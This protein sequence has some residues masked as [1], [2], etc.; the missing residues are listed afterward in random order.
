MFDR[1]A[2]GVHP[3]PKCPALPGWKTYPLPR[4]SG[5]L[6]GGDDSSVRAGEGGGVVAIQS[7]V[8]SLG[9]PRLR[10]D[11]IGGWNLQVDGEAVAVAP[12]VQRLL[13][14]VALRDR[15][16]RPV[17]AAT[18]WPDC[19]DPRAQANLRSAI[20]RANRI[21]VDLLV[22]RVGRLSLGPG[23]DV[24]VHALTAGYRA[25]EPSAATDRLDAS[26]DGELLPGW[27]DHWVL[28]ERELVRQKWL[29]FLEELGTRL[30]AEGRYEQALEATLAAVRAE[31][32]RESAHRLLIN[33]HLAEGN[34]GEARRSY[35]R[36]RNLLEQ[37][38]GLEP[39]PLCAAIDSRLKG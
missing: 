39:S 2:Q 4:A 8:G 32:L 9:Q 20:W 3:A 31:P 14:F 11:L 19:S 37:E 17:V 1:D 25:S 35:Q 18:L 30:T 24:D 22:E 5:T 16:S 7:S 38:L 26:A 15:S 33:I 10:L 23:A 21:Q 36:L 12:G 34:L 13:A 27:Y 29:H 28:A 6:K